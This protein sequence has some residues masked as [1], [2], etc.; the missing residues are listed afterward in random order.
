MGKITASV[1]RRSINALIDKTMETHKQIH[2][3]GKHTNAVL[4]PEEDWA[5][6]QE[7]H[8]LT[9]IPGMSESILNGIKTPLSKC[10]K[11]L[12]W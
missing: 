8:Y 11:S 6:I 9:S 5:A 10:A 12:K 3:T 4:I 2:I 1:A 7:T